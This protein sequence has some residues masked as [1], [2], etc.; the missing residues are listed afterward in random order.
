MTEHIIA[1]SVAEM[2]KFLH[3]EFHDLD[4]EPKRCIA[5]MMALIMDYNEFLENE[6]MMEKF[7]YI[8]DSDEGELH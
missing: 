7:D 3:T 4:E 5:T 1:M 6:G 8:Y 2:N